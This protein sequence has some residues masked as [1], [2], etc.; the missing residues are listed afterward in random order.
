MGYTTFSDTPMLQLCLYGVSHQP[1]VSSNLGTLWTQAAML[2]PP[3]QHFLQHFQG[4]FHIQLPALSGTCPAAWGK[5]DQF[6]P[7]LVMTNSSPWYRWP[8]DG[9]PSY[10]MGGSF[11]GYDTNN[12]MVKKILDLRCHAA[13]K[14]INEST[15][16]IKWTKFYYQ[17]KSAKST[18]PL[19]L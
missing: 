10:K 13:N 17:M 8:I 11:H 15:R 12:Q 19:C 4:S 7:K 2:L 3:L 16:T 6:L 5:L 18:F 14:R 1:P 9:L